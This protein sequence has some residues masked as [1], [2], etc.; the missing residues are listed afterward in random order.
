MLGFIFNRHTIKI[1]NIPLYHAHIIIM[2]WSTAIEIYTWILYLVQWIDMLC[3][4]HKNSNAISQT[5]W[6]KSKWSQIL[7]TTFFKCMSYNEEVITS[8]GSTLKS[9]NQD[10]T[11]RNANF[12]LDDGLGFDASNYR[13]KTYAIVYAVFRHLSRRWDSHWKQ[14]RVTLFINFIILYC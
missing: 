13:I 4:H 6:P 3:Q 1:L 10:L 12:G 2:L 9:S 11:Y 5:H 14:R 7:Q 8:C